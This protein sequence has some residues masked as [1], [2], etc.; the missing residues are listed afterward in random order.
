LRNQSFWSEKEKYFQPDSK[1]QTYF[2]MF[3]S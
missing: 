1:N 3:K 2:L